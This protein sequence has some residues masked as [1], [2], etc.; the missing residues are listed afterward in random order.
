[1][2]LPARGNEAGGF[3][4]PHAG[5]ARERL[6]GRR[7]AAFAIIEKMTPHQPARGPTASGTT[8]EGG[9]A[10]FGAGANF[11]RWRCFRQKGR[12]CW[13]RSRVV[14]KKRAFS[15][16]RMSIPFVASAA[17]NK[18][19]DALRQGSDVGRSAGRGMN[20]SGGGVRP[21]SQPTAQAPIALRSD[22]DRLRG[23]SSMD[24]GDWIV[25]ELLPRP[26]WSSVQLL[27]LRNRQGRA[28]VWRR[29]AKKNG[30]LIGQMTHGVKN[31][32]RGVDGLFFFFFFFVENGR[33]GRPVT[34]S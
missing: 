22:N 21:I 31:R 32:S 14:P 27:L 24:G 5:R 33:S 3:P 9:R 4:K 12:R 34:W 18:A 23:A 6:F 29:T 11:W 8:H 13:K 26:L 1:M 17:W 7:G 20:F 19:E 16:A 25:L 2:H 10:L 30:G 15:L 28:W